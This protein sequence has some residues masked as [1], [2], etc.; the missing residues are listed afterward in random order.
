MLAVVTLVTSVVNIVVT[1]SVSVFAQWSWQLHSMGTVLAEV[2]S[3]ILMCGSCLKNYT[4]NLISNNLWA[5]WEYHICGN[6]RQ[7][8]IFADFT[9]CSYWRKFYHA[10]F[11]SCVNDYIEDMVTFTALAK[12]YFTEYFCNTKRLAKFL[13]SENFVVYGTWSDNFYTSTQNGSIYTK[14]FFIHTLELKL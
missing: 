8:K 9:I 14:G 5:F 4:K 13:S 3:F 6:F 11:L 10:N 2:N 1:H 12:I 7:E